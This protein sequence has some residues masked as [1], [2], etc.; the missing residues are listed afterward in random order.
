MVWL[1]SLTPQ[2][3]LPT[4]EL[5]LLPRDDSTEFGDSNNVDELEDDPK[6][7]RS[8]IIDLHNSKF[9]ICDSHKFSYVCT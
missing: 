1:L 9:L 6:C 3:V 2:V 8:I 5:L 4:S 7:V